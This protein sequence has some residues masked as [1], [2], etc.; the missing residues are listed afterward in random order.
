MPGRNANALVVL[1]DSDQF[2][3]Q[4]KIRTEQ[5]AAQRIGIVAI[6]RFAVLAEVAGLRQTE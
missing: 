3:S 2:G 1:Q 5:E 6:K 4:A